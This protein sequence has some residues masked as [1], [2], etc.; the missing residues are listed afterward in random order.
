MAALMCKYL[1]VYLQ[2]ELYEHLQEIIETWVVFMDKIPLRVKSYCC[3]Q[4]KEHTLIWSVTP[5]T[6]LPFIY[7]ILFTMEGKY[8]IY[9][10]MCMKRST[11][12]NIKHCQL[13]MLSNSNFITQS[14]M[15]DDKI[16]NVIKISEM[17][18]L[19]NILNL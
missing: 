8:I 9:S 18:W 1:V 10:C 11:D 4:S 14:N 19:N 3:F 7:F 16:I 2:R 13:R 6:N 15:H 17:V 12:K 5:T